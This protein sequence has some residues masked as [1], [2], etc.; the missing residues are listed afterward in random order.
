MDNVPIVTFFIV[1]CCLFGIW[2]HF[3]ALTSTYGQLPIMQKVCTASAVFY[4]AW[5]IYSVIVWR[6]AKAGRGNTLHFATIHYVFL[7]AIFTMNNIKLDTYASEYA[8]DKELQA[9]I[10]IGHSLIGQNMTQLR[11]QEVNFFL[12]Q[13]FIWL[14]INLYPRWL[15]P[16]LAYLCAHACLFETIESDADQDKVLK[17][18][19]YGLSISIFVFCTRQNDRWIRSF[20]KITNQSYEL[21]KLASILQQLFD[22]VIIADSKNVLYL[23]QKAQQILDVGEGEIKQTQLGAQIIQS[24]TQTSIQGK[25]EE[26]ISHQLN[27]KEENQMV[28]QSKNIYEDEGSYSNDKQSILERINQELQKTEQHFHTQFMIQDKKDISDQNL[29]SNNLNDEM[30]QTIDLRASKVCSQNAKEDDAQQSTV[31]IIL[32][33]ITAE[34]QLQREKAMKQYQEIML[35]SK[36]WIDIAQTSLV[37]LNSLVNDTLD[38]TQMKLGKF[39]LNYKFINLNEVLNQ[40][41]SMIKIQIQLRKSVNFNLKISDRIPKEFFT[42]EQRLKQIMINIL[43]NSVKFTMKGEIRMEAD[44]IQEIDQSLSPR[45]VLRLEFYDTG[46]GIKEKDQQH[47]FKI[48]GKLSDPDQINKEGT[49]L[50]LYI[51]SNLVK[52]MN[53]AI[54]IDSQY[55]KYT[56]FIINIPEKI[57]KV[58]NF[59]N[60]QNISKFHRQTCNFDTDEILQVSLQQDFKQID[61]KIDVPLKIKSEK[62]MQLA[63]QENIGKISLNRQNTQHSLCDLES[64]EDYNFLSQRNLLY[65]QNEIVTVTCLDQKF[66]NNL[67][68]RDLEKVMQQNRVLNTPQNQNVNKSIEIDS[69]SFKQEHEIKPCEILIVDDNDFNSFTLMSVI[70]MNFGFDCDTASNGLHAVEMVMNRKYYPYKLIFM[71]LMMPVMDGFEATVQIRNFYN[72]NKLHPDLFKIV[73]L[74]AITHKNEQQK[75]LDSGMN[76]FMTKPPDIETLRNV[77]LEALQQ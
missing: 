28:H 19:F 64:Q 33:D 71:D 57:K 42:D 21:N 12:I 13:L 37:F 24:H 16:S 65:E 50:G 25:L 54:S 9:Q 29:N 36:Q 60:S 17:L 45:N 74:S 41:A 3:K 35:A 40:V 59:N 27:S 73:G 76:S 47:L 6:L 56:R 30:P 32:R 31:L 44:F 22:G 49:G 46:L 20:Y 26:Y 48:F 70:K 61:P 69:I 11:H 14:G 15:L 34:N 10:G 55:G 18:L 52:Q 23:N 75:A 63:F 2:T 1:I 51:T 68:N 8:R 38:Y 72:Q 66:Q 5:L 53:G 4:I 58:S 67:P 43:R 39:S 77:I 62:I 7:I